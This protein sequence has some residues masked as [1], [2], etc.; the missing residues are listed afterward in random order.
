M[1]IAEKLITS[2]LIKLHALRAKWQPIESSE[3]FAVSPADMFKFV[4]FMSAKL[5]PGQLHAEVAVRKETRA[6]RGQNWQQLA[7]K[8]AKKQTKKQQASRAI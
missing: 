5:I 2:A 6:K 4:S 1:D 3:T 8:A 7:K